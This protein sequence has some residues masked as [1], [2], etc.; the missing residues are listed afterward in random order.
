LHEEKV[1]GWRIIACK[2]GHPSGRYPER[3][4]LDLLISA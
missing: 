4:P 2:D 1:D 3:S